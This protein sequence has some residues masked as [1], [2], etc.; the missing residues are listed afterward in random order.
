M[1]FNYHPTKESIE[2]RRTGILKAI[3]GYRLEEETDDFK[4]LKDLKDFYTGKQ[5]DESN[6][7]GGEK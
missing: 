4:T 6:T 2:K 5:E 7:K 1:S 3:N